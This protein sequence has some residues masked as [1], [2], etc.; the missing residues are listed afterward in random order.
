VSASRGVNHKWVQNALMCAYVRV[1]LCKQTCWESY[2]KKTP[3][4]EMDE[5]WEAEWQGFCFLEGF[6]DGSKECWGEDDREEGE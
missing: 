6:R 2:T 3:T 1:L 4:D 5:R